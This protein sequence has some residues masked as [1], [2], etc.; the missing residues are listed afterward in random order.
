MVTVIVSS[1]LGVAAF[2]L[3]G[4]FGPAAPLTLGEVVTIL[5]LNGIS[6]ALIA[7]ML[8][9]IQQTLNAYWGRVGT[10]RR[11][12]PLKVEVGEVVLSLLGVLSWVNILFLLLS[13]SYRMA[14]TL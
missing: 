3:A 14:E 1:V 5:V 8:F 6:I 10:E 13:P 2:Q 12:G 4:G 11:E 7:V 9:R